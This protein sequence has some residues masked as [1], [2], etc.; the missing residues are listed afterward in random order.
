MINC[1]NMICGL[2]WLAGWSLPAGAQQPNGNQSVLPAEERTAPGAIFSVASPESTSAVSSVSGETLFRTPVANLTNTLYGLL[3]GVSVRQGQGEPGNDAA[4]INIRGIGAYNYGSY[5]VFVDGF[6]STMSYAQYLT[7]AEIEHVAVLK[8]A[9]AL[10]VFGM[11]GANGVLWITTKRGNV[12]KPTCSIRLRG[13]V[14]Q[15]MNVTKPLDS[16]N[17]ATLYNEANSNDNDRV[18]TPV[19]TQR[20]LENYRNG[21]GTDVD[22]YD[23]TLREQAPFYSV[24]LSFSGGNNKV[25]YFVLADFTESNGMY[26]VRNDDNHANAQ[27]R[28]Y[29]IR[30]NFDFELFGFIEGRVDFGGR[31]ESRRAPAFDGTTLW[32]N[33]ER[34]P[35]N[36]YP[37]RNNDGSWTGTMV[38]PNNPVASIRELGIHTM[39]DRSMQSNFSLKERLD[40]VTPGLYLSQAVSFSNWTRGTRNVTRNYA[41]FMNSVIQTSDQDT[42]YAINDDYGTNQWNWLQLHLTLG[43]NRVFGRHSLSSGIQYLQY[44]HNVDKNMN[45][46]SG[47]NTEYAHINLAARIHYAY[48]GKYLA[49]LN[50]AYSG[51]DNYR[52]GKRFAFY[53]SVSVG[54]VISREDFMARAKAVNL[55][56]LR[57]SVGQA[58]YDTFSGGRYL[59]Q[60][61]YKNEGSYPVG[62]ATPVWQ[63]GIVQPYIADPDIT[64]E[65]STKYNVGIDARFFDR[66]SLTADAFMD[67]RTGIV[68]Q[69]NSIMGASGES[70]CYR[71]I[72]KVTTKGFEFNL[73]YKD[74]IGKFNYSVSVLGTYVKDKI[75]YMAEL[76]SPSKDARQT[77]NPIGTMLGYEAIGFYDVT[78]FDSEGNLVGGLPVPSL[79]AVQ[80]GD[81]KYRNICSDGVIDERDKTV[82]GRPSF[83][84]LTY[85]F[86]VEAEY[87][88]FDLRAVLQGA[89]GRDVNLLGSAY[90]KVVAFE[91]NGNVYAWAQ[92][93]WAYYPSEGIDTRNTARY[94]RLSTTA[95]TNNYVNSSFWIKDGSFLRLRNIEIG[96]SLPRK[97]LVKLRMSEAR[98][99]V[100]GVN[101]LTWSSLLRD[102]DIDPETLSGYPGVKSYNIGLSVTF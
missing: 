91:N 2:L 38:Y 69:D 21:R 64:A 24:D 87:R 66:L 82:I 19:Y 62:N 47:I 56:K 74:R 71:N 46:A 18:W 95:N 28:Q 80:P 92:D 90:N 35:R 43:Y 8:D 53:P 50:G 59:Y 72:G 7:A 4:E 30:S 20:Q 5:A 36:I 57:I 37:V 61:Y 94:P 12:G 65:K 54:W 48:A 22:W 77:G 76:P 45:G 49:E 100:S 17:Y 75:D 85:A 6:Q 98:I 102:Y 58:G 73:G 27:M 40:F 84:E 33:L 89:A 29:N 93:R 1:K 42:N 41:R 32:S 26:N 13:G 34:Y 55:L 51:S 11:K 63:T 96:Y 44:T 79:G 39:H 99:Y 83:P 3:P 86:V 9:A 25:R 14:Q 68:S 97:W 31:I 16:Y 67:R 101:L 15:L 52:P 70:P 88:G 60:Q 78:D 23:K 10:A 81:I